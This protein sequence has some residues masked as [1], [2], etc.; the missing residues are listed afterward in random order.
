[1]TGT[2]CNSRFTSANLQPDRLVA[3]VNIVGR[4]HIKN[5]KNKKKNVRIKTYIIDEVT[6]VRYASVAFILWSLD[7]PSPSA[8]FLFC[9]YMY[10]PPVLIV[11]ASYVMTPNDRECV[12]PRRGT[13]AA[14]LADRRD[15][16]TWSL[17][18]SGNYLVIGDAKGPSISR[19]RG[20]AIGGDE[21]TWSDRLCGRDFK[22]IGNFL[23]KESTDS[24]KNRRFLRIFFSRILKT[25]LF[26]VSHIFLYRHK[27]LLILDFF[28]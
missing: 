19:K 16:S 26:G 10:D 14:R 21:A 27:Y 12:N 20:R 3:I 13:V 6:Y 5:T 1:M 4:T 8:P 2:V 9:S 15:N 25:S 18:Q 22:G 28:G 17:D 23:I 24:K 11:D 7:F